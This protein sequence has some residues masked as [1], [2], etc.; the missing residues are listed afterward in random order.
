M[1]GEYYFKFLSDSQVKKPNI[2][3]DFEKHCQTSPNNLSDAFV[4]NINLRF[5]Q[6]KTKLEDSSKE[7]I[8]MYLVSRFKILLLN[9]LFY[10]YYPLIV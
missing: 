3:F 10:Q 5:N 8:F 2:T 7:K 6:G 9:L 1:K 4:Q